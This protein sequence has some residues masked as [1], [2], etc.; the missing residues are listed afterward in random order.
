MNQNNQCPECWKTHEIMPE[1]CICGCFLIK[2]VGGKG[3]H[4]KCPFIKD[5]G[6]KCGLSATRSYT[7]K[8]G[9]WYCPDH[10]DELQWQSYKR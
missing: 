8:N 2:S 7:T 3:D 4:Q 9:S 6:K 1:Q 10:A 5:N